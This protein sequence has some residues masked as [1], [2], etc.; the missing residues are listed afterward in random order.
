MAADALA[1]TRCPPLPVLPDGGIQE[2]IVKQL[3]HRLDI[4]KMNQRV[5]GM[6]ETC[7]KASAVSM[8]SIGRRCSE[9]RLGDL[10]QTPPFDEGRRA[11]LAENR[12]RLGAGAGNRK[13][14]GPGCVTAAW[15]ISGRL[16]ALAD[17]SISN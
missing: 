8:Q 14:Q 7:P 10:E 15:E 6:Q 5:G 16:P 11:G 9:S 1:W 3:G 13:P 2:G 17:P 12:Q 4:D